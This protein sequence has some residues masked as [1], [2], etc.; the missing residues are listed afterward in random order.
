MKKSLFLLLLLLFTSL[1]YAQKTEHYVVGRVVDNITG[2][3]IVGAKIVLSRED[4]SRIATTVS[5]SSEYWNLNGQ[6]RL[7]LPNKG[8]Y[9]VRASCVGYSEDSVKVALHSLR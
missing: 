8:R 6:Y 7:R 4:G 5:D 1:A 2:D 3:G 9:V